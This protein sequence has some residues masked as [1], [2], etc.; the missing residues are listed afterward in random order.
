[1]HCD[2]IRL[3]F[4]P[5]LT[6]CCIPRPLKM[7]SELRAWEAKQSMGPEAGSE[8]FLMSGF[9]GTHISAVV[10]ELKVF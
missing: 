10:T 3:H 5:T 1:M 2:C 6:G 8:K 9:S 4:L 7:E